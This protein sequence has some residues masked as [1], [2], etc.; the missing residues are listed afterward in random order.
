MDE[1]DMS[2]NEQNLLEYYEEL[3]RIADRLKVIFD[4][5]DDLSLRLQPQIEEL[6]LRFGK[7]K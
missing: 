3:R 7:E 4:E 6:M 1:T 2:I 5:V